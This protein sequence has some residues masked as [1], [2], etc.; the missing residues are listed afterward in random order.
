MR[1]SSDPERRST[2][3]GLSYHG[4][5]TLG[6]LVKRQL[7]PGLLAEEKWL[8]S[9]SHYEFD[10]VSPQPEKMYNSVRRILSVHIV[11]L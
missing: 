11:Y 5:H 7:L 8:R 10:L 4:W 9:V 6:A 1:T 3:P 2:N